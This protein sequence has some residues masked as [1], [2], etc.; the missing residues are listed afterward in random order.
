MLP[1]ILAI[2]CISGLFLPQITMYVAFINAGARIIYTFMYVKFG[3][4]YRVIGAVSGSLPLY[5]L[6]IAGFVFAIKAVAEAE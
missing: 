3:S 6:A 4:N 2:I 1:I 5:L